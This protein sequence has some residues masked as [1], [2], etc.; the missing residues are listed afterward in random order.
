M[1]VDTVVQRW[2]RSTGE[3]A[4]LEADGRSFDELGVARDAGRNTK[5]VTNEEVIL[6][7]PAQV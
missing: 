1:L 3:Q 7:V 2:Q 6:N 5:A 4:V